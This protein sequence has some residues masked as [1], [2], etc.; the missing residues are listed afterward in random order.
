M[1][2]YNAG[3]DPL[4]ADDWSR[5]AAD[6][7]AFRA[8]TR[9]VYAGGQPG[10]SNWFAVYR[11]SNVLVC[12]TGGLYYDWD[13][14]GIPN[15]WCQRY[16]GSKT[17]IDPAADLDGDGF[18]ALDEFTAYT[19]PTDPDSFLSITLEPLPAANPSA[20]TALSGYAVTW[21]SAPGRTYTLLAVTNLTD[22]AFPAPVATLEGTGAPLSVPIPDADKIP[23]RFFRL[24]VSLSEPQPSP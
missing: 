16:T 1:Q 11:V 14:D 19:D 4:A 7:P 17:G 22:T 3:T 20:R 9:V 8:D 15:W 21:P 18:T 13:G 2:E 12:D 23:V 5:A 10:A 6:S 24:S